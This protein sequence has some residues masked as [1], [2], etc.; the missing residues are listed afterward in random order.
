[1]NLYKLAA[2]ATATLYLYTSCANSP[3]KDGL[4]HSHEHA[5]ADGHSEHSHEPHKHHEGEITLAESTAREMGVTVATITPGEFHEV[6][7]VAGQIVASADSRQTIAARSAGIVS[8]SPRIA[9]GSMVKAGQTIASVSS[10]GVAGGDLNATASAAL[11][12]AKREL[13]RITPL[14][15]EGIV[16][17][18]DYNTAKAAYEQARAAY[19][20]SSSGSAATAGINGV[21]TRLLVK[22]GEYVNA[23]QPIA[24]V[25]GNSRMTLRADVPTR[26]RSF[27]PSITTANFRAA[28]SD[29]TI[30]LSS[31]NGSLLSDGLSA[32]NTAGYSPVYF[33]MNDNGGIAN[34]A[35]AEVY[36]I[37][38]S[39]QDV[40]TVPVAAVT[41]QQGNHYVY[42]KLDHEC[43]ERRL[44]K[45]GGNDGRNVEIISGINGGD[46]VVVGGATVVKLA[47]SS[48]AVPEGHSHNH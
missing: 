43:Y 32:G 40:I 35:F 8:L 12:A 45:L 2:I 5:E 48:G 41:E 31:V 10:K 18:R 20:G 44:V 25:S 29:S 23:G 24:E 13:D 33:A 39:R 46:N 16:S 14:H 38:A 4:G 47:E 3:E 11:N 19:S 28:G 6:L 21:I 17:T 27:L 26:N 30:S 37:G 42:V 22:Q 34:G 1:M 36:L 7:K 9:E 15:K